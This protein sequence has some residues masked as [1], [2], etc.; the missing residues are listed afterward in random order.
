M[1]AN[2][3]PRILVWERSP[4]LATLLGSS[5]S[6]L[7]HQTA[8]E[9]EVAETLANYAHCILLIDASSG[10][11][12]AEIH[13]LADGGSLERW[14]SVVVRAGRQYANYEPLVQEEYVY[15]LA[16]GS[17]ETEE[18]ERLLVCCWG[19]RQ[20]Q[21]GLGQV[22]RLVVTQTLDLVALLAQ[23]GDVESVGEWIA[24]AVSSILDVEEA[25]LW[26]YEPD[27]DSCTRI[28][29]AA[30]QAVR[31]S[32]AVGLASYSIRTRSVLKVDVADAD[33]RYDADADSLSVLER[34]RYLGI[35]ILSSDTLGEERVL[36]VLAL[37]RGAQQ[38]RFSV[39][40]VRDA[41][42]VAGQIAPLLERFA[43]E[44]E[45]DRQ[46]YSQGSDEGALFFRREAVRNHLVA[47]SEVGE[48]VLLRNWLER[49]A[50]MLTLFIGLALIATF[51][52]VRVESGSLLD[53]IFNHWTSG[54]SSPDP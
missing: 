26:I 43:L 2:R 33:S 10:P 13:R 29:P 28:D 48:P 6:F 15:F 25:F 24:T 30:R 17:L 42:F 1:T 14:Q 54:V 7:V 36:G 37:H 16:A 51:S 18:L 19:D 46:D 50:A 12:V 32:A 35:P 31:R 44:E 39:G 45:L 40:E 41:R 11:G 20:T 53:V 5:G 49:N 47:S 3:E 27:S 38:S 4:E 23:Q 34:G 9:L 22:T 8:S 21:S 52:L